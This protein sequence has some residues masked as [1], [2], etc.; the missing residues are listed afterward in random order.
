M[1]PDGPDPTTTTSQ[2]LFHQPIE[3]DENDVDSDSG[4]TEMVVEIVGGGAGCAHTE[5]VRAIERKRLM[6]IEYLAIVNRMLSIFEAENSDDYGKR[7]RDRLTEEID[8]G[9]KREDSETEMQDANEQ[10]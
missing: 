10:V 6:K 4:V 9:Q 1:I 3:L 2:V 8:R 5:R 7:E